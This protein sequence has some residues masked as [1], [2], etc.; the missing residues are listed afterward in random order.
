MVKHDV[1]CKYKYKLLD[2][3]LENCFDKKIIVFP[4]VFVIGFFVLELSLG[5]RSEAPSSGDLCAIEVFLNC[6]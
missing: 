5:C 3:C 4:S 6:F 1:H 2:T